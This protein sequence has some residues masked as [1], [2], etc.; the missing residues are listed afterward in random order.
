MYVLTFVMAMVMVLAAMTYARIG[1]FSDSAAIHASFTNYSEKLAR[2]Y[3]NQEAER[4]YN[5]HHAEKTSNNSDPKQPKGPSGRLNIALLVD[6]KAS[7]DQP[8]K[9]QKIIL[10]FKRLLTALY[11][12]QPFFQEM[13]QERPSFLDELTDRI[14]LAI[15]AL[16][17]NKKIK[18][19]RQL[20]NINLGD[21]SLN[22]LFYKFLHG[23]PL[24]TPT[25]EELQQEAFSSPPK[26]NP[27]KGDEDEAAADEKEYRSPQG[28]LSV[29]DFLIVAPPEDKIR[30]YLASPYVLEAVLGDTNLVEQ[31]LEE[32]TA[33]YKLLL[34]GK[35]TPAQ[36]KL[37]LER[38]LSGM[39]PEEKSLFDFTV[40]KTNPNK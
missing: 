12:N 17:E 28:Y 4:Q 25:D 5:S 9:Q 13:E 15:E 16:P 14:I 34:A 36:G 32:R 2:D 21:E 39:P 38:L 18:Q 30:L 29:L 6:P 24:P 10:Y 26:E 40:S 35:I 7:K 19:A 20:A 22:E 31:L 27:E 37:E 11:H 1:L 23:K 8:L 33:I 3:I